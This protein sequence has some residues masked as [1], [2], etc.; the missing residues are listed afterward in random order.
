MTASASTSAAARWAP[1]VA[2]C[3]LAVAAVPLLLLDP[4]ADDGAAVFAGLFGIPL[5]AVA[6]L[7]E[8]MRHDPRVADPFPRS[9]VVWMLAVLPLGLLLLMI[10][11][12]V[13]EPEYFDAESLG[14]AA[15]TLGLMLGVILAGELCGVVAW[16]FVA[17]PIAAIVSRFAAIA[18]GEK[19]ALGSF[20]VPVIGLLVVGFG[21]IGG[22]ALDGLRPGRAAASQI[23]F[24]LLGIPGGYE[25][26]WPAGLWIVR[27]LVVGIVLIGV[28]PALRERRRRAR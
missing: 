10:P 12:L 11:G 24:A 25:V 14:G 22:L 18:R 28:V 26:V 6:V 20:A 15:A 1:V 19:V 2:L 17:F 27:A 21:V 5:V 8:I 3:G 9:V 23:V 4:A 13:R 7:V 16:F